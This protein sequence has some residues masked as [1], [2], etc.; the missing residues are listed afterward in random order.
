MFGFGKKKK[1]GIRVIGGQ[2]L[3]EDVS[4]SSTEIGVIEVSPCETKHSVEAS[5]DRIT[6]GDVVFLSDERD[7]FCV[8]RVQYYK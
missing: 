4:G 3:L 7:W 6:V 5:A 1:K 2:T 8:T